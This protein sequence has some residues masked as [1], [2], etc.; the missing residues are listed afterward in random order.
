M[1][2][3]NESWWIPVL[4]LGGFQWWVYMKI[5]VMDPYGSCFIQVL[6]PAGSLWWLSVDPHYVSWWILV[7]DLSGIK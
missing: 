4:N 1:N 7:V 6:D 3:S 2:F 5:N